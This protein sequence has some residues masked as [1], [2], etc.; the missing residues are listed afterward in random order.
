MEKRVGP[1]FLADRGC[2]TVAG[3]KFHVVGRVMI[4]FSIDSRS[5]SQELPGK[6]VRPTLPAKITS[7]T[8]IHGAMGAVQ[9]ESSGG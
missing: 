4:F 8:I 5:R 6:L 7:P 3:E 1:S 9:R 2:G